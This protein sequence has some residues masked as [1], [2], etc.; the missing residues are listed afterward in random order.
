MMGETRVSD[1]SRG[2]T[3]SLPLVYLVDLVSVC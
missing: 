1:Y 2:T 3:G